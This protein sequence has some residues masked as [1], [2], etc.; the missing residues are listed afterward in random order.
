MKH[1]N[2]CAWPK[3]SLTCHMLSKEMVLKPK[4]KHSKA[5]IATLSKEIGELEEKRKKK[6][7]K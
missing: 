2:A 6:I 3:R 4:S 5:R 7:S 1:L